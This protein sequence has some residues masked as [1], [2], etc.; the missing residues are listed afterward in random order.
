MSPFNLSEAAV[1]GTQQ[2]AEPKYTAVELARMVGRSRWWVV[3][4]VQR[5]RIPHLR[6]GEPPEDGQ[7]DVR[8][9]LFTED[10]AQ[11]VYRRVHHMELVPAEDF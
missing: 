1:S 10:Q 3:D 7:R 6:K 8:P 2:E 4:Q 11:Q 5:G 9:I